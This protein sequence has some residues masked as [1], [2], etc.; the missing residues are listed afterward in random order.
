MCAAIHP[1][2]VSLLYILTALGGGTVNLASYA[3]LVNAF[4]QI[5]YILPLAVAAGSLSG[6]LVNFWLSKKFV[7]KIDNS[8]FDIKYKKTEF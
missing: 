4:S 6:M 2:T 1:Y 7:F 3:M 5:V 8:S